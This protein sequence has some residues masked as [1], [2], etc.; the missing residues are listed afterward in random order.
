MLSNMKSLNTPESIQSM[1]SE[2]QEWLE[3]LECMSKL[4][5]KL[6]IPEVQEDMDEWVEDPLGAGDLGVEAWKDKT[7]DGLRH[8]LGMAV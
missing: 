3:H 8:Y 2:I 6:E 4:T 5:E 1:R 7:K